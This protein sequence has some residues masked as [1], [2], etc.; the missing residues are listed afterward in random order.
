MLDVDLKRYHFDY[1][2]TFAMLLMHPDG[3]VYHRYGGRPADDPLGWI[4]MKSLIRLLEDTVEEHTTY[5]KS[6]K[7]ATRHVPST[8]QDIPQFAKRMRQGKVGCVHCHTVHD[9][10]TQNL[11]ARGAF[12][13]EDIWIW[14][15][16]VRV[17]L[18]MF[19]DDQERIATVEKGSPAANAGLRSGDR[20]ERFGAHR[21]RTITDLQWVLHYTPRDAT[22]IEVRYRRGREVET[23]TLELADGWRRETPRRYAWRAFKWGLSPAPGFGGPVLSKAEKR[24]LDLD[25]DAFAFRIGYMVTWGARSHRGRAAAKA[26]LRQ[27]DIVLAIDDKTDFDDIEHFHAWIRLTKKAGDE[28]RI[29]FVRRGKERTIRYR[30]PE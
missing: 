12:D 24:K 29:R 19:V 21:T 25:F 4:S 2:L 16:P 30:L 8:I 23:T 11:V 18:T 17:G 28:V 22:E 15:D 9:Y 13:K 10:Q 14:P 1:D 27:G 6:P 20:I 5:A 3:T 7:P 26:G